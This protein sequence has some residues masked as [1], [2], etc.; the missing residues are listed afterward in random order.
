MLPK[1]PGGSASS[2]PQAFPGN[3]P[4]RS[5][6]A[7]TP[8]PAAPHRYSRCSRCRWSR[9]SRLRSRSSRFSL[10]SACTS[11]SSC[12]FSSSWALRS[13]VNSCHRQT[14]GQTSGGGGGRLT[15]LRAA[16]FHPIL[17]LSNPTL[18]CSRPPSPATHPSPHLALRGQPAGT[19]VQLLVGLPQSLALGLQLCPLQLQ[20]R[21]PAPQL[22][23]FPL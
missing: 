10:L 14:A 22:P 18:P 9:L 12:R 16:A 15:G 1:P 8:A 17:A 4:Q 3:R 20:P 13:S 23:A 21:Q 2:F 6:G 11:A 7:A 19:Q 5:Q